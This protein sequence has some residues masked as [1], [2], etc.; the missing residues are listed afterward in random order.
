MGLARHPLPPPAAGRPRAPTYPRVILRRRRRAATSSTHVP[1]TCSS[2]D[3]SR[4]S[5]AWSSPP[6][7]ATRA[8][9]TRAH[10]ATEPRSPRAAPAVHAIWWTVEA[11]TEENTHRLLPAYVAERTT[12]AP[13]QRGRDP[14]TARP[15]ATSTKGRAMGSATQQRMKRVVVDHFGG[16]EGLE[17]GGGGRSPAGARRGPRQAARRRSG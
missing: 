13:R 1:V 3:T 8:K 14:M 12:V 17:G 2:T 7:K 10:F 11:N 15:A 6:S 16:P 4:A 5:A 9:A